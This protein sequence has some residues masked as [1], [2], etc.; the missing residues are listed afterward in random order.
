[1]NVSVPTSPPHSCGRGLTPALLAMALTAGCGA[2]EAPPER[3]DST[4]TVLFESDE[5]ALGPARDDWPKFL[6]FLPLV[7][8]YGAEATPRLAERWERSPDL[9]TWTLHLRRDVRWHDG[10]PVTAQDIAF[11]LD[12]VAHPQVLFASG[13]IPGIESVEVPD[14]STLRLSWAEPTPLGPL[15]GWKVF[16]PK[17]LLE[18]LEP[19]GFF[20]WEF[21]KRPVGNGP[22]RFVR[23]LPGT[24]IEL[25]ANPDFYAGRPAVDRVIL[26]LAT[27]NKVVEL[28]SGN[29]DA[30]Y[31][32]TP[33]DVL[34]L[35]G[36]PRFRIYHQWI[37]SEPQAIYWNQRHP[38]LADARVRRALGHAIDRRELARLLGFPDEMPLVGGLSPEFQA[39]S[40]YRG[41]M[42]DSGPAYDPARAA[43]L[44]DEAGWRD[45]DGDGARERAGVAAGFA[46]LVWQG[47]I[48]SGREPALFI[49]DQLRR[50]GIR[51]RIEALDRSVAR[52]RFR[53]RD[54]DATIYDV[55]NVPA[56]LLRDDWF[57]NGSPTGYTN[58]RIAR[59]LQELTM[60]PDAEA[61]HGLYARINEI[62]R[63]DA[64]VT[65]LFPWVETY[66]AHRRI[67]GLRTPDRA[68]PLAHMEHLWIEDEP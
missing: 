9:R 40:L 4:I 49:Q 68:Q 66:A 43:S 63:E 5:Y 10:T 61:R 24:M 39:D 44:L 27:S 19:S 33:A 30:V 15:R 23:S 47:G 11:T 32:L 1:M 25:E 53:A 31:Y 8:G 46:L 41:G 57:G 13:G 52:E 6:V 58:E 59:L 7:T 60:E 14:D 36:D 12:L 20:R 22:Y 16:F 3:P 28:L 56:E 21:W 67:R 37:H 34:K 18:G 45:L 64:P 62:L 55:R 48:M 42:W 38:L 17:H 29:V 26:K 51:M 65:F 35:R 54:Y 2:G 50:V